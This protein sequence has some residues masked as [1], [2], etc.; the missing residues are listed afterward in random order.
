MST[1]APRYRNSLPTPKPSRATR[2][3]VVGVTFLAVLATSL[4]FSLG[5]SALQLPGP[6]ATP[7]PHITGPEQTAQPDAI[8]YHGQATNTGELSSSWAS[9]I[10]TAWTLP[11]SDALL[12][13]QLIA[14]GSTLYALSY[15]SGADAVVTVSAYDVSGAEPV[16]QWSTTGPLPSRIRAE[17]FPSSVS[18]QDEILLSDI[19]VDRS[20]G[21]QTQAPWGSDLPMG[22]ADGV[23]VTCDTFSSCSGWSHESGEWTT[24]WSTQT[25]PQ[26]RA[27]LAHSGLTKPTTAVISSGTDKAVVVPV[28]EAHFAPQIIN[29][30]TGALTT[31]GEAPSGLCPSSSRVTL[32]GDGLLVA[33]E[34]ETIAYNTAGQVVG[35]FNAG[36]ELDK[37][38][39]TDRELPSV[40]F[41]GAFLTQ[42]NAQWTS[43]ALERVY[44]KDANGYILSLTLSNGKN[45]TL[46]PGESFRETRGGE[47]WSV[48][49][50]RASSDGKALYIQGYSGSPTDSF[51]FNA[52]DPM[53]YVSPVMNEATNF[54]WVYDDLL[55]G[56]RADAIVA[57]TPDTH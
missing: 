16:A 38:P 55:V 6:T 24:L 25:S 1:N 54:V 12:P 49:Q 8:G 37:F 29:P 39:T 41:L 48:A 46:N 40:A 10:A 57:F 43:G 42:G 9:G 30:T 27:G 15:G 50:V 22:V 56:A 23:L 21:S 36:W 34:K 26:R 35:T 31:L 51:F 4:T 5:T 28:D 47:G 45:L 13:A 44:S 14:E 52:E 18:T 3:F 33:G 53:T 17:A 32:A 7:P 19:I 11:A 2:A 20:T